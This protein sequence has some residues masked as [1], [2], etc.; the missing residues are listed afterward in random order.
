MTW[1]IVTLYANLLSTAS[2]GVEVAWV[3]GRAS[4][5]S[6]D[7]SGQSSCYAWPA[8]RAAHPWLPWCGRPRP[9]P[10]S[11]DHGAEWAGR[12]GRPASD[13]CV[14]R[15]RP[16]AL[17]CTVGRCQRRKLSMILIFLDRKH[18]VEQICDS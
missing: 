13:E 1:P 10:G 11:P 6:F 14:G 5:A 15:C 12:S 3:P 18:P 16:L 8:G 9:F 4:P 7:S 17:D 2:K